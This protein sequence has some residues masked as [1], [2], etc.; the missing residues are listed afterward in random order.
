MDLHERHGVQLASVGGEIDLGT[1]QGRLTA[2]IKGSVAKHESEQL[3]RRVKVKM[4]ERAE[5]GARTGR[6]RTDG[7]G[8]RSTTTPDGG[9]GPG[10]SS[11]PIKPMSSAKPPLPSPPGTPCEPSPRA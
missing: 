8:S 5:A 11:I 9:L 1:P 4:A 10:T 6:L 7:V 3:T 2:R